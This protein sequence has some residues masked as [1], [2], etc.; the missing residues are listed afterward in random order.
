[1]SVGA[2]NQHFRLCASIDE[3]LCRIAGD[4]VGRVPVGAIVTEHEL[5][6]IEEGLAGLELGIAFEYAV[7]EENL[8]GLPR[9]DGFE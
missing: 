2:E 4:A 8:L 7:V 9:G 6:G 1:M 5:A 3:D